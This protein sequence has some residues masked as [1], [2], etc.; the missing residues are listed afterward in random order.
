MEIVAAILTSAITTIIITAKVKK[1][2]LNYVE[3]VC[4]LN[5]EQTEKIKELSLDS[6]NELINRDK[7][8]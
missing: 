4:N 8:G 2:I 6:I 5:I 3:D 7:R 1:D